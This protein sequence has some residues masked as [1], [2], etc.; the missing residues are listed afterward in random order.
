MDNKE[1]KKLRGKLKKTQEQ[2]AQLLGV[3]IKAVHSYEQ[4][5]LLVSGHS[6]VSDCLFHFALRKAHKLPDLL[7][8][9][10]F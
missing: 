6:N 1:F 2:I 4:G 5:S 7:H 10:I 3:S 9:L 8:I